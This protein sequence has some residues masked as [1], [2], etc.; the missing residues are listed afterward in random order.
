MSWLPVDEAAE[1]L[2]VSRASAWRLIQRH[3][4]PA[5]KE[6]H[7]RTWRTLVDAD[8][9]ALALGRELSLIHISEPTE[10]LMNLVCRLLLEKK[11]K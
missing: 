9:L 10:T 1:R 4:I 6:K 3:G 5:R 11:K 8:L 2:G 7:G